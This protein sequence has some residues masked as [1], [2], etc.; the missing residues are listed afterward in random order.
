MTR[1]LLLAGAPAAAA[2]LLAAAPSAIAHGLGAQDPNRPVE[3]YLWLGFKH[4]LA[5][6]DH[7]LFI[8]AIV[9]LAGSLWRAT[10]LISLFVLGHSGAGPAVR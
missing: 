8:L 4:L 10:K 2:V 5:G 6:W 7:L 3:E 9:L 1:R